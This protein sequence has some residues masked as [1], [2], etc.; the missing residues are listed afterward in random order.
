MSAV[1]EGCR[2]AFQVQPQRIMAAMYSCHVNV[3][4]QVLGKLIYLN[5]LIPTCFFLLLCN[6]LYFRIFKL[7]L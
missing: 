2:K 3:K 5:Y 4:A 6:L 7:A 1:K